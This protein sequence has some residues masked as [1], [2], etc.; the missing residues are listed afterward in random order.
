VYLADIDNFTLP[1]FLISGRKRLNAVMK[2]ARSPDVDNYAYRSFL[3]LVVENVRGRSSV[4]KSLIVVNLAVFGTM[5]FPLF[6][7]SNT[8]LL[9]WGAD[10]GPLSL[11][12]QLWRIFTSMFVHDGFDHILVNMLILWIVGRMA[13]RIFGRWVYLAIYLSSGTA[14]ALLSLGLRPE[15]ITCGASGAI[16]GTMAALIAALFFGRLPEPTVKFQKKAWMLV[17]FTAYS[18]Y[19]GWRNPH[20]DNASHWGAAVSGLTLGFVLTRGIPATAR[21]RRMLQRLIFSLATLILISAMTL[22]RHWNG[23]VVSLELAEQA[24]DAGNLDRALNEVRTVLA[25]KPNDVLANIELGQ[26]CLKK[27]DYVCAESSL[28]LALAA[29]P[30]NNHAEYLLGLVYLRTGRPDAAL[31]AAKNLFRRRAVGDDEQT[32]FA[33]ALD[34]KGEHALA[35]DHFLTLKHYDDAIASFQTAMRQDPNDEHALRGLVQAYRAKGMNDKAEEVERRTPASN[36]MS[37]RPNAT[38]TPHL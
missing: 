23:Y 13:E 25:T 12:S 28:Q 20:I 30:E 36:G 38:A 22:I 32:L 35:G 2:K 17:V 31:T 26:I 8:Q 14:G 27:K 18:L 34:E 37:Q 33:A 7:S 5:G 9:K 21:A 24:L 19:S 15:L 1:L 6:G 4:T 16:F 10:W 11:D 29:S 3:S